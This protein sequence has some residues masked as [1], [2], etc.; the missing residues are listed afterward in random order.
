M[1]EGHRSLVSQAS[2][3][4]TVMIVVMLAQGCAPRPPYRSPT[5]PRQPAAKLPQATRRPLAYETQKKPLPQETKIREQDLQIPTKSSPPAIAVPEASVPPQEEYPVPE[6]AVPSPP[7]LP[8][9]SSLLAKITSSTPPSRA[10]SL[11]LAAEGKKL[12]DA[13]DYPRA[14]NRLEKSIA[15]DSTNAYGYFY[16]AKAH[17]LMGRYKE[18]LNFLDVTESRLSGEP[19]WLAEVYALRGEDFRALGMPDRAEE[20]YA[21]ALTINAGNRTASEAMSTLGSD[22]QPAPR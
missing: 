4:L 2:E 21:K 15:I 17:Y 1:I 19:F 7:V 18:S 13:G 16:I 12:L 11:R 6:L 22:S 10:A 9:D 3:F 14:L 5:V 8:D 20:S